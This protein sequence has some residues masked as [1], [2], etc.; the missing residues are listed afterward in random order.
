MGQF[1]KYFEKGGQN[2]NFRDKILE[3]YVDIHTN[4]WFFKMREGD[5]D[6]PSPVINNEN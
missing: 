5:Y 4:L 1:E 3:F 6:P 2:I